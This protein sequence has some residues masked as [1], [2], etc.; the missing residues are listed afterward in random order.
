M[1]LSNRV[2]EIKNNMG[3]KNKPNYTKI[4]ELWEDI[5]IKRTKKR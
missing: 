2:W 5:K 3:G 4:I 1:Y